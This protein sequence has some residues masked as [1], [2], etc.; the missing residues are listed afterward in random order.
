MYSNNLLQTDDENQFNNEPPLLTFA[1]YSRQ[2]TE[3][4]ILEKFDSLNDHQIFNNV[5][6][7]YNFSEEE[8]LTLNLW[9]EIIF[10]IYTNICSTF[11]MKFKDLKKY[12]TINDRTPLGL[13]NIMQ[14]LISQQIY[15]SLDQIKEDEF[16]KNNFPELLKDK[17]SS[18]GI[19]SFL[20][21][22]TFCLCNSKDEDNKNKDEIKKLYNSEN[23]KRKILDE[24]IILINYK[25]FNDN[26]K[27]IL[28][29]I[30]DYSSKIAKSEIFEYNNFIE[31]MEKISHP[32]PFASVN[33]LSN[34]IENYQLEYGDLFIN[35]CLLFLNKKKEINIFPIE[36]PNLL[37]KKEYIKLIKK[38][39]NNV[40]FDI[41]EKDNEIAKM[42]YYN[43]VLQNNLKNFNAQNDNLCN[44]IKLNIY[45]KKI[46]KAKEILRKRKLLLKNIRSISYIQNKFQT[47]MNSLINAK[48]G[49][50][51][52][53]KA[54]EDCKHFQNKKEKDL[55]EYISNL[56]NGIFDKNKEN[57]Y[58]IGMKENEMN[59]NN[60][61]EIEQKFVELENL[62]NQ[63]N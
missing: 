24:N 2:E 47:K 50:K 12:T 48:N 15:I 51:E 59:Y 11:V 45:S 40:D 18:N 52:L 49:E 14:E 8:V 36:V 56:N 29:I 25:L 53:K 3:K 27:K 4:K 19:F 54:I 61:Q 55:K 33:S 28:I 41:T 39:N 32:N 42:N 37:P 34:E 26:C 63:E 7:E 58:R 46:E 6:S 23:E 35:E 22:A 21:K 31:Y 5:F 43:E 44:D 10:F 20:N 16:Y 9:K 38:E 30:K 57:L 17:N 13:N 60:N 1:G 62:I